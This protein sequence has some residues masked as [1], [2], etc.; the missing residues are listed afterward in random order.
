MS[1]PFSLRCPFSFLSGTI[2]PYPRERDVGRD[3]PPYREPISDPGNPPPS[4]RKER[5]P[6]FERSASSNGPPSNIGPPDRELFNSR[7]R[8]YDNRPPPPDNRPPPNYEQRRGGDRNFDRS[9]RDLT[10]EPMPPARHVDNHQP[11]P[12][13]E[14]PARY[15]DPYDRP[16][17]EEAAQ[18]SRTSSSTKS[19]WPVYRLQ[20]LLFLCPSSTVNVFCLFTLIA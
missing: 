2:G 8:D 20:L 6:R 1:F 15:P 3:Y 14:R 16:S 19:S 5:M 18:I 4:D 9:R 11:R 13:L 10:P 17:P 12:G 7:G